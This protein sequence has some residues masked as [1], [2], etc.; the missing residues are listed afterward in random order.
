MSTVRYDAQ[1]RKREACRAL[2]A[3]SS[4]L[5][6][7]GARR[8]TDLNKAD[9][10]KDLARVEALCQTPEQRR[11]ASE[12]REQYFGN[13]SVPPVVPALPGS[14]SVNP[15]TLAPNLPSTSSGG[16]GASVPGGRQ[17]KEFRLRGWSCLFTYS[18]SKFDQMVPEILWNAFLTWLAALTFVAK[19]TATMEKSLHSVAQNRVHLHAFLE[20]SHAVDWTSLGLVTFTDVRPNAKPT[21]ARGDNQTEVVNHGHFYCW[22]WKEGTLYVKTSGHEPWAEYAVKGWWIDQLW[23]EHKLSHKMYLEYAEKIRVGFLGRQ[24]QAEAVMQAEKSRELQMQQATVAARLALLRRP[25]R[26][27]V[28]VQVAKWYAQYTRDELR[29]SFLVLAKAL[30]GLLG[31]RPPYVQTVQNAEAAD[32]RAFSREKHGYILFDNVNDME[33][34]LSQRALFQSNNDI[35]TLGESKTGMYSYQVWLFKVPLVVTVDM[36]AVWDPMEPWIK[37]NHVEI[38]LTSPCYL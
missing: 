7:T 5:G 8:R 19:W 23:S 3:L 33:F 11:R 37:E 18:S 21:V 12:A 27:D 24:K 17:P 10:E 22:A 38:Y 26:Q 14:E 29:Y 13:A 34:V 6:T 9:F 16:Q 32:L 15:P 28:I 30:D 1:S 4:E 2:S 25:F 35:H 36:S 20:F 31:L